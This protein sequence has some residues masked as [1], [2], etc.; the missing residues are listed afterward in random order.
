MVEDKKL[1]HLS[2]IQLVSLFSCFTN[3]VV[4]DEIK[5]N[6]PRAKDLT[7]NKI[8]IEFANLYS[9]YKEKEI[10]IKVFGDLKIYYHKRLDPLSIVVQHYLAML[11]LP[12][13]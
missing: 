7:V 2:S 4:R 9:D 5:D 11:A 10:K 3:I 13:P 8:I 12:V 1:D 6:V